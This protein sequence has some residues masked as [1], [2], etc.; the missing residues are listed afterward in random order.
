[1]RAPAIDRRPDHGPDR[2]EDRDQ[3]RLHPR[4]HRVAAAREHPLGRLDPEHVLGEPRDQRRPRQ[5]RQ[6]VQRERDHT[7]AKRDAPRDGPHRLGHAPML[8]PR[9]RDR[10]PTPR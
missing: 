5:Q 9:L 6:Q 7:E 1:M 4:E 8:P 10:F 2:G 3:E